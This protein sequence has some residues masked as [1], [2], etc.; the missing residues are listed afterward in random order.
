M[1]VLLPPQGPQAP[2]FRG[3]YFIPFAPAGWLAYAIRNGAGQVIRRGEVRA[4]YWTA[5][6]EATLRAWLDLTDPL[7]SADAGRPPLALLRS[8]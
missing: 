4:D 7:P 6:L 3:I 5:E 2:E 1:P 8:S